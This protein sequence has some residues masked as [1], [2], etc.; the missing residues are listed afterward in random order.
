MTWLTKASGGGALTWILVWSPQAGAADL[1]KTVEGRDGAN[2]ILSPAGPFLMGNDFGGAPDEKPAHRVDLDPVYLDKLEV[3][4]AQYTKFVNATGKKPPAFWKDRK[5]NKSGHP[6]VGVSWFDARDYCRW[7]GKRLPTEAEWEKA[8]RTDS[9]LKYPWGSWF[10]PEF[11]NFRGI[12]DEF[13]FTAPVGILKGGKSLSGVRDL[14]GNAAEW[15]ADWY[16]PNYYARSPKK[17]PPGPS[18]GTQRVLR[19]GSW[20]TKQQPLARRDKDDPH[21]RDKGYGFRCAKSP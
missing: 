8:G 6:V 12:E 19:G 17:N 18:K 7:A 4:N 13:R 14:S 1:P 15:V 20:T 9:G 11:A 2:M 10:L 16:D 5:L 3:T 21:R